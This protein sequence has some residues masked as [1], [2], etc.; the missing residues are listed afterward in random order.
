VSP[1]LQ[2]A[3]ISAV[4]ALITAIISGIITWNQIQREKTKWLIDLKTSYAV[5]LYKTRLTSYPDIFEIL[6]RLSKH[7]PEPITPEKANLIAH[8]IHAWLY[9]PGGLCADASTRG[10]L[11]ELRVICTNWKQGERP[12]E[13]GEWRHSALFLVRRDLDLQGFEAFNAEERES[14]LKK[15][16]SEIVAETIREK[17][18]LKQ[19]YNN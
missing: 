15:V 1:E 10:A 17:K 19:P 2:T 9:S 6:G 3:L 18:R 11:K 7:A 14:L 4:V 8:E 12:S 5:E 16:Q 13:L